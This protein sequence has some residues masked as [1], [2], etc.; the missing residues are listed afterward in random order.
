V[1]RIRTLK[2]E[3]FTSP[4]VAL[5]DHPGRL[6]FQALWC[7]ADDF[8][9][10]ETNINGLLGFAFPDGD[11]IYNEDLRTFCAVSAQ[12]V[13]RFCAD[14]AR[15]LR[16]NFY[17]VRGRHYYAIPT[18]EEHQKL[19][20]RT[21]RRR[22][23]TPDDPDAVPDQRIYG[24]ADFAPESPRKNGANPRQ[25]RAGTGEQGNRGTGEIIRTPVQTEQHSDEP[26][27]TPAVAATRGADLVRSIIPRDHPNTTMTALRLQASELLNNGTEPDIVAD[28]LRLWCEKPGVGLGRTILS[29]M[30]SEVIKTRTGAAA[31]TAPSK[32]K[33]AVAMDLAA[34]FGN[35]HTNATHALE[36]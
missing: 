27:R 19:E 25:F 23:P 11:L 13:R 22:Y 18:W 32:R 33:V 5:L 28:A 3:F 20:K 16:V 6:F 7:W 21:Q 1:P 10:G 2:P 34:Q 9:I 8:G 17:T 4:D 24:G 29:S 36:A 15:V 35:E 26:P 12:D 14:C 30:C 31:K